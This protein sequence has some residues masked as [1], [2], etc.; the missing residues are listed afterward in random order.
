MQTLTFGRLTLIDLDPIF[1]LRFQ[2]GWQVDQFGEVCRN[3]L[4]R[5]VRRVGLVSD[6]QSI[7]PAGALARK[8]LTET[9][10]PLMTRLEQRIVASVVV[11]ESTVMRGATRAVLWISPQPY[12]LIAVETMDQA[13]DELAAHFA[14]E[15]LPVSAATWGVLRALGRKPG[16]NAGVGP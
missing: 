15:S 4:D 14:K 6:V 12:P 1:V 9:I 16:R 2:E 7:R 3:V 8:Q 13:A 10:R 11:S 5:P